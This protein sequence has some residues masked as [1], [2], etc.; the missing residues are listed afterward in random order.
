MLI[1]YLLNDIEVWYFIFCRVG[2]LHSNLILWGLKLW[3]S[4][5]LRTTRG[6]NIFF[7]KNLC[8]KQQNWFDYIMPQK[9]Q[10]PNSIYLLV[11]FSFTL[12]F[13]IFARNFIL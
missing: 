10:A 2:F 12:V 13:P 3:T 8:F 7:K 5:K 11:S 6:I 9:T 4:I 1:F